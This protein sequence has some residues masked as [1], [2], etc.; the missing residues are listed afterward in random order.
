VRDPADA[1]PRDPQPIEKF[2]AILRTPDMIGWL[3][4]RITV[5]K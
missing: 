2:K 4:V 1:G 5:K 3:R